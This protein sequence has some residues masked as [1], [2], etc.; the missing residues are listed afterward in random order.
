[1]KIVNYTYLDGNGNYFNRSSQQLPKK[2]DDLESIYN[3]LKI[4]YPKFYKMDLLSQ[5][6][7]ILT[8]GLVEVSTEKK[9]SG[10]LIWN[11]HSSYHSDVKHFDNMSSGISGPANFTYT[12]PNIVLGEIAI[13]HQ[14][15]G[16]SGVFLQ[17]AI[18]LSEIAAITKM[19]MKISYVD[20]FLVGWL[21]SGPEESI[22]FVCDVVADPSNID[23][24][25][26][27]IENIYTALF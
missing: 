5:L 4:D 11:K 24:F 12:L 9:P 26:T 10:L 7:L 13:R 8:E 23:I 21:D 25:I 3:Y 22:G 1:M 20:R 18:N 2:F 6:G 14:I 17:E 15:M 27:E 16:E 19:Y